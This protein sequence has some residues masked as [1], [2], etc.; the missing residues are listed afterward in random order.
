MPKAYDIDLRWRILWQKILYD[1]S[2]EEV[3]A[4]LF[5]C[6][7]TVARVHSLFLRTGDVSGEACGR[8]VGTTTLYEHEEYFIID[9]VLRKPTTQLHEL[10]YL[11]QRHFATQVSLKCLFSTLRR[12]G[13]TRKRVS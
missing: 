12:L 9:F 2:N 3:A 6:P 10:G 1:M 13:F 11:L 7:K 5:I 4:N 8:P